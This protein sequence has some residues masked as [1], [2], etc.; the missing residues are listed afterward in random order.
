MNSMNGSSSGASINSGSGTSLQL[1][2]VAL[3]LQQQQQQQQQGHQAQAQAQQ[4]QAQARVVQQ[5]A[6]EEQLQ[7][8]LQTIRTG[9]L[10]GLVDQIRQFKQQQQQQQQQEE[11]ARNALIQQAI[12]QLLS[13]NNGTSTT[14]APVRQ[15]Q[16]PVPEHQDQP[17]TNM[18]TLLHTSFI[19]G[20]APIPA[21]PS[22]SPPSVTQPPVFSTVSAPAPAPL[23][24]Q[25]PRFALVPAPAQAPVTVQGQVPSPA[26]DPAPQVFPGRQ[27]ANQVAAIASSSTTTTNQGNTSKGRHV[28]FPRRFYDMLM[29]LEERGKEHIAC[30]A[31]DGKAFKVH[32]RDHLEDVLPRYFK[33]MHTHSS[34]QRQLNLYDFVRTINGPQKGHYSHELFVKGHPDLCDNMKRTKKKGKA[35]HTRRKRVQE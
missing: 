14:A 31:P 33:T 22:V 24:G 30:F 19:P 34:L 12:L 9:A 32:D 6:N 13:S 11:Q 5:S 21:L 4:A 35:A 23:Q 2:A 17:G 3:L 27:D 10:E 15:V 18:E 1:A 7:Q 20:P 26:Q 8:I 28:E 25:G 16:V 29:D